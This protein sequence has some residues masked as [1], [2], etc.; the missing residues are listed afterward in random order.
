MGYTLL[1]AGIAL[2][3]QLHSGKS[4]KYALAEP[5]TNLSFDIQLGRQG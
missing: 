2:I 3:P 1:L 4:C 5:T